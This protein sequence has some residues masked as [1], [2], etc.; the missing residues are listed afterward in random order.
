MRKIVNVNIKDIMITRIEAADENNMT[1]EVV[2][3]TRVIT[4]DVA[5]TESVFGSSISTPT[6]FNDELTGKVVEEVNEGYYFNG[7]RYFR[8]NG[9]YKTFAKKEDAVTERLVWEYA[10]QQPATNAVAALVKSET[11][12]VKDTIHQENMTATEEASEFQYQLGI[13]EARGQPEG[14]NVVITGTCVEYKNRDMVNMHGRKFSVRH[15]RLAEFAYNVEL[16]EVGLKPIALGE[17]ISK[18]T[19]TSLFEARKAIGMLLKENESSII[20]KGVSKE[21]AVE[22]KEA[23]KV[24]GANVEILKVEGRS[25]WVKPGLK[26]AMIV[27]TEYRVHGVVK[28]MSVMQPRKIEYEVGG[29]RMVAMTEERH[30]SLQG[31]LSEEEKM[32]GS[33]VFVFL[34]PARFVKYIPEDITGKTGDESGLTDEQFMRNVLSGYVF[35]EVMNPNDY[36]VSPLTGKAVP[37]YLENINQEMYAWKDFMVQVMEAQPWNKAEL[38]G[39]GGGMDDL[40]SKIVEAEQWIEKEFGVGASALMRKIAKNRLSG[41]ETLVQTFKDSNGYA[42]FGEEEVVLAVTEIEDFIFAE[43]REKYKAKAMERL[44]KHWAARREGDAVLITGGFMHDL[45]SMPKDMRNVVFAIINDV[46]KEVEEMRAAIKETVYDPELKTQVKVYN[47]ADGIEWYQETVK[48]IAN[49]AIMEMQ[50]Q[51]GE[52][53]GIKVVAKSLKE[54]ME[55]AVSMLMRGEVLPLR[56][57]ERL[58]AMDEIEEKAMKIKFYGGTAV[59]Q[60]WRA[61]SAWQMIKRMVE[62]EEKGIGHVDDTSTDSDLREKQ[63]DAEARDI[64]G[65]E[66]KFPKE[67]RK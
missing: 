42:Q 3:N 1:M 53:F 6:F 61:F 2:N 11:P 33:Q 12:E 5:C 66:P 30:L 41:D 16:V 17:L 31:F 18:I 22:I 54:G 43:E 59:G 14:A 32:S 39:M 9:K 47:F 24:L 65:W 56:G 21:K 19:E 37:E 26:V 36:N 63:M 50:M 34:S 67:P 62:K 44:E 13:M 35:R 38:S 27:G 51:F 7:S 28:R 25:M 8:M 58:K 52:N 4:Y 55:N 45:Y 15:F 57:A 40:L 49:R 10:N 48:P 64:K 23:L 60:L 20:S 29:E 46:R